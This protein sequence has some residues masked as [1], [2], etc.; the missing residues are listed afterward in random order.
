MT[1]NKIY[2][3]QVYS[4][5]KIFKDNNLVLK[6]NSLPKREIILDVFKKVKDNVDKMVKLRLESLE[7]AVLLLFFSISSVMNYFYLSVRIR[8]F[9]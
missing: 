1:R 8:K 2:T 4:S 9:K 7:R 6:R 3:L 5:N